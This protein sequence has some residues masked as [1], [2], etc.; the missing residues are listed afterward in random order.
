MLIFLFFYFQGV[1][2]K[3]SD[4]CLHR[5]GSAILRRDSYR[6]ALGHQCLSQGKD[7]IRQKQNE[8]LWGLVGCAAQLPLKAAGF[9]RLG[10]REVF[11]G[12]CQ[13]KVNIMPKSHSAVGLVAYP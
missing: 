3:E 6:E 1:E 10:E 5:L 2:V 11:G 4:P 8:G 12:V 9:G 13:V 7:Y